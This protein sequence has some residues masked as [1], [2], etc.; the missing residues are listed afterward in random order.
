MA[1]IHVFRLI[2]ISCAMVA[3]LV[4]SLT[5]VLLSLVAWPVITGLMWAADLGKTSS[6]GSSKD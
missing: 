3:V 6:S 5:I 4:T 1:F 2:L